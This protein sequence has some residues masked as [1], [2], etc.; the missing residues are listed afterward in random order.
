MKG[1]GLRASAR[2]GRLG[3]RR[4]G[5]SWMNGRQGMST[6]EGHGWTGWEVREGARQCGTVWSLGLERRCCPVLGH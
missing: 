3:G 6:W 4:R 5:G 1:V 2:V